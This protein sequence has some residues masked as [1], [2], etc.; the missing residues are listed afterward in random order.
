MYFIF[1]YVILLILR[2]VLGRLYLGLDFM[3]L[4]NGGDEILFKVFWYYMDVILCCVWK[5]V[6]EVYII[7]CDIFWGK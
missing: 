2:Y 6:G 3:R 1:E 7:D 5:V 4:E